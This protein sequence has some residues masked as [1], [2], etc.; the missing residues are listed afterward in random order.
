MSSHLGA[1][2]CTL[3]VNVGLR[4]ISMALLTIPHMM[5]CLDLPSSACV[6]ALDTSAPIGRLAGT[7]SECTVD[8]LHRLAANHSYRVVHID[9]SEPTRGSL[10]RKWFDR[11]DAP[12]CC[13]AGTPI[14]VFIQ[15]IEQCDTQYI[16][17]ADCDMLF[18]RGPSGSWIEEGIR[19]LRSQP[20]VL[21]VNQ[22]MGPKADQIANPRFYAP[23]RVDRGLR[24]ARTFSSRCFLFDRRKLD[25]ALPMQLLKYSLPRRAYYRLQGR[26][27]TFKPFEVMVAAFLQE[28]SYFR[29]DLDGLWG[30]NL[31]AWDK[32]LF[33]DPD[34][35][36]A[37]LQAVREGIVPS[38]QEG[39]NDLQ[40]ELF[41]GG[42]TV[43]GGEP[44]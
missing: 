39:D 22:M 12:E 14:Y 32:G 25:A 29:C 24:L 43:R 36:N 9:R 20:D 6:V 1:E 44:R 18:S 33:D 11:V 3:I 16:L 27:N 41:L 31:H 23:L 17:H 13:S 37:V 28:R 5:E 38:G 4:D 34:R 10:S 19:V 42:P 2:N 7:P 8:D 40:A 30:F 15:P 26:P 35:A 21:F